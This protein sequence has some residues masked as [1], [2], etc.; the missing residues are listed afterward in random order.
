MRRTLAGLATGLALTL[1]AGCSCGGADV[2]RDLDGHLVVEGGEADPQHAAGLLFDFGSLPVGG[3][4]RR[5]FTVRNRSNEEVALEPLAPGAP[6]SSSIA[7]GAVLPP[8]GAIEVELTFAPTESST[9]EVLVQLG[10]RLGDHPIR[11]VGEGLAARFRCAPGALDFRAVVLGTSRTETIRCANET[12][13]E[14]TLLVPAVEGTNAA[15]FRFADHAPGDRVPIAA[16]ESRELPVVFTPAAAEMHV[17]SFR[18]ATEGGDK[19][20]EIRLIG[21]GQPGALLVFPAAGCLFQRPTPLGASDV[22]PIIVVNPSTEQR[23]VTA[24][25]L[26]EGYELASFL[27]AFVPPDDLE[28]LVL[29]SVAQVAVRFTP[30]AVGPHE[31]TIRLH[32]DDPALPVVEL[33]AGGSGG[34]PELHCEE[35][36]IDFGAVAVEVPVTRTLTCENR[37]AG[38]PEDDATRL[39]VHSIG[40]NSPA[41][42]ASLRDPTKRSFALGERFLVDVTAEPAAEGEH[43]GTVLFLTSDARSIDERIVLTADAVALPPCDYVL[44]PASLDFGVVEPGTSE[45][46]SLLVRNRGSD[47]CLV[48]DVRIAPGSHPG[49]AV[50]APAERRIEP[51]ADLQLQVRFTSAGPVPAATGTLALQISEPD[52][53]LVEVPLAATAESRCLELSAASL[54]FGVAAPGCALERSVLLLNRCALPVEIDGLDLEGSA[55]F[56]FAGPVAIPAGEGRRVDLRFAPAVTGIT[57]G[58]LAIRADGQTPYR[59]PLAGEGGPDQHVDRW[60]PFEREPLDLLWVVDDRAGV[61]GLRAA[62]AAG[63]ADFATALAGFDLQV[64][65]TSICPDVDGRLLPLGAADRVLDGTGLEALGP[66]LAAGSCTAGAQGRSA[67]FRAIT[68]P[69]R[70]AVDDPIHPEPADGNAGFFRPA[71]HLGVLF[72]ADGPDGNGPD[73]ARFTAVKP[74]AIGAHGLFGC[75]GGA[76]FEAW[77]QATGGLA[78]DACAG[79]GIGAVAAGLVDRIGHLPLGATPADR[80]GDGVLSPLE[81]AVIV[82][83][84]QLQAGWRYDEATGA[85]HFAPGAVPPDDAAIEVRYWPRCD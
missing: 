9:S 76:G 80:D 50:D 35:E 53:P 20:P 47:A 38:S 43:Y 75:G 32:T 22:V 65:V 34:G 64:G 62:A 77:V 8:R 12:A 67:A 45:S 84:T 55:A 10:S 68:P 51:G 23:S 7:A 70:S 37:G 13:H 4:E 40:T 69:L 82:D 31:G 14:A 30:A 49:F 57:T 18:L 46:R 48:H 59:L 52:E 6:F 28:D 85:I 25:E 56:S 72:L 58:S 27:P 63:V 83:G 21:W 60:A 15:A 81:L 24:I 41:F 33:C 5:T 19:L 39:D 78:T 26:P 66:R 17:G 42:Y 61:E 1:I 16:G 79:G 29:T 44:E 36:R 2:V 74:G 3:T 54:D 71:A 73:A 11:L